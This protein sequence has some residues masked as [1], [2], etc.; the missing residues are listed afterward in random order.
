M[1]TT[2]VWAADCTPVDFLTLPLPSGDDPVVTALRVAYPGLTVDAQGV[3]LADG[4]LIALGEDRSRDPA[5]RLANPTLREQFHDIYPLRFDLNA[6]MDAWHDPGR[7]RVEP[8]FAALYGGTE[9]AVRASLRKVAISGKASASFLISERHGAAC[10]MRAALAGVQALTIDWAPAFRNVAGS[11]NWRQIAGTSRMSTHS[12]GIAFDLNAD[13]GGYWRWSK[14]PEGNAGPYLNR[15]P[16]DVVQV[17]E[18]HGFIWG[19]KWHHFDGMH[20]EYRPEVILYAR[21]MGQ[22]AP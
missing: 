16:Q 6:R 17:F 20:F 18:R 7:A 11:F 5:A 19:G 12:Y 3:T 1:I 13:L 15:I 21:L 9:Q 22:A 10:Q 14:R 2:P 8:L 4:S